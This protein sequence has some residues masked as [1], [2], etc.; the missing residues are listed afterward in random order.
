MEPLSSAASCLAVV[1]LALQLA[2]GIKQLCEFWI[3][4]KEAPDDIHT[5]ATD[6]ELLSAVL[7]HMAH[8]AQQVEPDPALEA[9]LL[10]CN[11]EVRKLIH[12]TNEMEPGFASMSR[13][14]RRWTAFKAVLNREKLQ[15]FQKVLE[16]LKITLVL[17]QQ[18]HNT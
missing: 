17:A 13:R 16:R 15:R 10:V 12:L 4:V 1:S 5:I 6:L 14:I 3:S 8:E 11:D 7:A 9:A 18:N 2:D